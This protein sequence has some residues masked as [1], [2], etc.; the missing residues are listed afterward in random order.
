MAGI[1]SRNVC[2]SG[3][4]E[5]PNVAR[6]FLGTTVHFLMS[7]DERTH[8]RKMG[9]TGWVAGGHGEAT[10]SILGRSCWSAKH[11]NAT[12]DAVHSRQ[13]TSLRSWLPAED[14]REC[15]RRRGIRWKQKS[16]RRM[17]HRDMSPMRG[18][19]KFC[20]PGTSEMPEFSWITSQRRRS[21]CGSKFIEQR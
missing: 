5:S 9:E 4:G 19:E 7:S 1:V 14:Q 21:A 15:S 11:D 2:H 13:R 17:Q 8:G 20:W 16:R 18:C 3:A 6:T 10:R 12:G